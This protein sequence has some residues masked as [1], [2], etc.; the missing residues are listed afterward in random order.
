[1]DKVREVLGGPS[2]Q[3]SSSEAVRGRSEKE[4]SEFSC[5]FSRRPAQRQKRMVPT[6]PEYCSTAR[7]HYR[8]TSG[9]VSQTKKRTSKDLR[10]KAKMSE[11]TF[12]L[13]ADVAEAH[14][15]VPID[16]LDWHYLGAQIGPG[17]VV[18]VNTV[19]T[20]GISSASYYWSRVGSALCRLSQYI[21]GRTAHTWHLLV[22]DDFHLDAGVVGYREALMTFFLLCHAAGMPLSWPKTAGGD[23]IAWVG[24]EILHRTFCLGVSERRAEWFMK[25]SETVAAAGHIKNGFPS[26]KD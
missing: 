9:H 2:D 18:Y 16:P 5:G 14:R 4:V 24:F 7:T 13:T 12:A 3:G 17:D 8:S 10:E 15:Q 1:M 25:W 22:A 23:T 11:R 20:F 26:K 21:L 19:G 6:L